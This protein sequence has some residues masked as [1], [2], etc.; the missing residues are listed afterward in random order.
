MA[1]DCPFSVTLKCRTQ[2]I[3]QLT[4]LTEECLNVYSI[5]Y[6]W[7]GMENEKTVF[8]EKLIFTKLPTYE[9]WNHIK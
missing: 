7:M 8:R 3:K 6:Y 1:S 4:K 5:A 9:N 2:T